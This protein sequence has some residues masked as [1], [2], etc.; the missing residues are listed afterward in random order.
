[1]GRDVASRKP[2]LRPKIAGL[3]FLRHGSVIFCDTRREAPKLLAIIDYHLPFEREKEGG[4]TGDATARCRFFRALYE[5]PLSEHWKAWRKVD[6][7]PMD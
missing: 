2:T 1:L 5:F 6:G 4:L 7:Q 3:H